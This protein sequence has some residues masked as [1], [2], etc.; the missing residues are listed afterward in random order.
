MNYADQQVV[1][2]ISAAI[3]ANVDSAS[4]TSNRYREKCAHKDGRGVPRYGQMA[5]E[6]KEGH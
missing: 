1:E 5:H 3:T 4:E 6:L 2:R